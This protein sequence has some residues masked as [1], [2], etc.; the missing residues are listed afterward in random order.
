MFLPTHVAKLRQELKS[1]TS[2]LE[3]SK[4][5]AASILEEKDK[6]VCAF[7]GA[8]CSTRLFSRSLSTASAFRKINMRARLDAACDDAGDNKVDRDRAVR[9]R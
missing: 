2:N 1:T 7:T 8:L 5:A 4:A 3:E 9:L 6:L